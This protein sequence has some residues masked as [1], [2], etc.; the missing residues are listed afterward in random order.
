MTKVIS[1]EY[2]PFYKP[3]IDILDEQKGMIEQLEYSLKLF[4][5]TLYDI[6]EVKGDYSYAAGKWSLKELV[7]HLID[8]ERVFVYRALRFS[9]K[10]TTPL[11]GFEHNA[12]VVNYEVGSRNFKVMLDEFCFLRR[13]TIMMFQGIDEPELDLK[14]PVEGKFISVRALGHICSGHVLHHLKIISERYL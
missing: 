1:N 11:S 13:S 2:P 8:T 12:Y 9:R 14:G 6:D 7:Q 4:E 3:Y 10:D 5:N